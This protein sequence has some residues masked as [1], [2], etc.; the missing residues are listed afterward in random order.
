LNQQTRQRPAQPFFLYLPF[1]EPHVA[2]HPLPA[3]IDKFPREWDE[4]P[5]RGQCGY[6]PHPRPRAGY[7]AMIADL[8]GYVGRILELLDRRG[9]RERTLVVFSSDNGTTHPH[10][11]DPVFHVGG[12]D[13]KF[14]NSTADLRGFKGSVYEGGLRVPMI[15]SLPG[16]IPAG[17]VSDAP[18][19][20]ADWLPT[21]CEALA[22]S[23][24]AGLDGESL[25]PVLRGGV[26]PAVRKPMV[27]VFPEYGGQVAVR[28]GNFK[29]LRQRLKTKQPGPWELYD[30]SSD[31]GE[32]QDLAATR[33]DV[34]RHAQEL[35]RAATNDNELFPVPFADR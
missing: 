35:L 14:F 25:W 20:F 7:A 13:A 34:V 9:L 11:G 15:A 1:I 4:K 19:Y 17:A 2:M 29:A 12:V 26:V 33:P 30:L 23:A 8:D 10:P 27:W 24:P 16:A 6:T 32:L 22:I 18:G 31:R 21:L 5:Y 28:M 3:S